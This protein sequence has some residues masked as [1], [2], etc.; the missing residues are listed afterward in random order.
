[1]IRSER[2]HFVGASGSGTTTLAR[3]VAQRRGV[4]AFDTDDFFW[5]PTDPPYQKSRAVAD[6]QRLMYD[7]LNSVESWTLSGSLCGW[8]DMFIPMFD[9][10]VFLYLPHDIRMDRLRARNRLQFGAD[11]IGP[12]GDM[13]QIYEDFIEWA[14]KYDSAG[15]EMRSRQLHEQWLAAL[16][17]PVLRLESTATVDAL[18]DHVV[19]ALE[20]V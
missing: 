19:H 1:V 12:G 4:S 17:C 10:V 13:Q 20:T 16:P 7:A 11:R 8:G 9:L 15:L 5:Q 6:R 3:A 18:T 2:I 14:I